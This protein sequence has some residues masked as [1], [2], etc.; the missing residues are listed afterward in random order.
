MSYANASG[1]GG[2]PR[3]AP[4]NPRSA[5]AELSDEEKA[6]IAERVRQVKQHIPEAMDFVKSLHAEG[7]VDGLRCIQSVTVFEGVDHGSDD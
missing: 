4:A 7:L 2:N 3:S 6:V 1:R 5:P